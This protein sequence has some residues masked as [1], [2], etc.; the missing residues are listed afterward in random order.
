MKDQV[1]GETPTG[2]PLLEAILTYAGRG[3]AVFPVYEVTDQGECACR[4]ADCKDRGKHPRTEHG[5]KD[6]TTDEATIRSWWSKW[7]NANVAIAT[8]A[9]SGLIVLDIDPRHQGDES[10]RAVE[11]RYGELPKTPRAKSGSGGEHIYLQHPGPAHTVRNAQGLGGFTG[12][13]LKGDGGYIIA[14]PSRHASGQ[15]YRWKRASHPDLRAVAPAPLWVL[16]LARAPS[17]EAHHERGDTRDW[18]KLLQGVEAGSRH[19][20]ATQIAGHYLGIGW[21][22]QEVEA[23]LLGFAAQCHPPHDPDDIRRIVSDFAAAETGKATARR[24]A[25]P[26]HLGTAPSW[27]ELKAEALHGLAGTIVQ[28][29]DRY[30]EADPVAVLVTLLTAFGNLVGDGPHFRVEATPHPCRLFT[31]LVGQT[32]KARKGTAWSTPRHMLSQIDKAWLEARV[33]GGLSSGEGLINAVR[34]RRVESR[35]VKAKGRVEDYEEVIADKGEEDKRLF[36]VEEEFSQALKVMKREGNILSPVIRQAWDSGNLRPL[37][38]NNPIRATGAHISI[39]GHITQDELLRHLNDIEQGNGFANRFIWILVKRSK[40]LSNP[41]GTPTSK[42]Q[43]LVTQLAAC[44]KFARNSNIK[45]MVRTPD[46]EELWTRIYPGLSEGKPGL[47]G[48]ILARAE[49]QV[50]R[51]ACIYA[52]LDREPMI[53]AAH[54]HAALAIWEY[55]EASAR[56]IFG[57]RLGNPD[58]DRILAALR[59]RNELSETDIHELFNRH[60]QAADIQ[61]ALDLLANLGM[62]D[63][64]QEETGGRPRMIWKIPAPENK[65]N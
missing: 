48:A 38:K 47:L 17:S 36:V 61:T 16:D 20:V 51:L 55:A 52:L 58:A 18:L 4:R 41:T 13:D 37:T 3:W 19:T 45:T 5:A 35:P 60:K 31:V 63:R 14:D 24:V 65:E 8:G 11:A 57:T 30:T 6:A 1:S 43:P 40:I 39:L 7:P 59:Q 44:V 25:S 15:H 12:L 42:L 34:D 53:T 56:R 9:R 26:V 2:N 29:I 22:A 10:L 23:L 32:A 62:A 28:T 49:I 27:P 54:L 33:T 50:L 21:K 46:A 64:Y